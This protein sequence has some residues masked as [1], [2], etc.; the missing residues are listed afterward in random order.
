MGSA[1]NEAFAEGAE[2]VRLVGSDLPGLSLEILREALDNLG[3]SDLTLGPATD[4]GYYLIGLNEPCPE[5]FAGPMWG[6][7]EVLDQTLEIARS[8]C[9]SVA[10]LPY[11]DDVDR[12][13][14]LNILSL[15]SA[16]GRDSS[17]EES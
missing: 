7:A 5:L 1:I 17:V 10:L 14:D 9:L 11:L 12:P 8:L 3:R 4:G 2:R 15:P 13:E 6:S 16:A